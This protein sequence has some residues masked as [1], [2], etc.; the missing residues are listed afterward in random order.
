VKSAFMAKIRRAKVQM[1]SVDENIGS[2][3]ERYEKLFQQA[4]NVQ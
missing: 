3:W 4:F 1:I 2:Q